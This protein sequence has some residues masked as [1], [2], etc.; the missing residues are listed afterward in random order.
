V[1]RIDALGGAARYV[2]RLRLD[3]FA[4]KTKSGSSG[5]RLLER[6]S[7]Y[8]RR[9]ALHSLVHVVPRRSRK[10]LANKQIEVPVEVRILPLARSLRSAPI[11]ACVMRAGV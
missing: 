1:S 11:K 4:L 5:K 3:G 6:G 7:P 10:G 8:E 9:A 2:L